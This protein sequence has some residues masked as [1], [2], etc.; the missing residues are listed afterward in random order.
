[1]STNSHHPLAA[2]AYFDLR[3]PEMPIYDNSYTVMH[4]DILAMIF[5]AN[6]RAFDGKAFAMNWK[7]GEI[8][9]VR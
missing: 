9:L 6:D 5:K 7:T 1:M 4:E 3:E 2:L 8:V